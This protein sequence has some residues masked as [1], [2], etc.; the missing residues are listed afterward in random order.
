MSQQVDCFFMER[1]NPVD[2]KR[3][4]RHTLKKS[5]ISEKK[6]NSQVLQCELTIKKIW[7]YYLLIIIIDYWL[8][9]IDYYYLS[10][11]H[12]YLLQTNLFN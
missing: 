6:I 8:L 9:I 12:N 7:D 3:W 1:P 5:L 10:I 2:Q 11:S 4:W